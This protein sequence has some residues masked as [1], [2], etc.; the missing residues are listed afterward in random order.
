MYGGSDLVSFFFFCD[1]SL[2]DRQR[3]CVS[4]NNSRGII[5]QDICKIYLF[6]VASLMKF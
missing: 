5:M 3:K 1:F 2:L 6:L 4:L